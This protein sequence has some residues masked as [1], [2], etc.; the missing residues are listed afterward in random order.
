MD[1]TG[2]AFC[3][4][5]T[6]KGTAATASSRVALGIKGAPSEAQ[7]RIAVQTADIHFKFGDSNVT[8]TSDDPIMFAGTTEVFTVPPG[9]THVAII[10]DASTDGPVFVTEGFGR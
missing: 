8:A 2:K 7:V 9:A 3:P 6:A 10:R 4:G 1:K 5:A